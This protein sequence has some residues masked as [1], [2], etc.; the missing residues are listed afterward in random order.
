M[1]KELSI[2]L[3]IYG[4]AFVVFATTHNGYLTSYCVGAICGFGL[5]VSTVR[6]FGKK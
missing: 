3:A 5:G 6:S 1:L 4:L 2:T